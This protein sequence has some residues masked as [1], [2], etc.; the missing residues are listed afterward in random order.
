A[1]AGLP[2]S[3]ATTSIDGKRWQRLE[4]ST[5]LECPTCHRHF[6]DPDPRHFSFNSPLGACP[7]CEGF[8]TVSEI[9]M[10]KIVPDP[11]KTIRGGAIA[12]WNT[13]KHNH[14]LDELLAIAADYEIPVDV[15][16]SELT[17]DQLRPI[18]E[19]VPERNFGGLAG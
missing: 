11:A 14:E 4:F 16:F 7:T 5:R 2:S 1:T 10:K 18:R 6:A 8:G 12:P 3:S 9:D 13:P 15:P 19:G 17:D